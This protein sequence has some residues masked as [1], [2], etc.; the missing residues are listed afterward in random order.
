MLANSTIFQLIS[1]LLVALYY[2]CRGNRSGYFSRA[3]LSTTHHGIFPFPIRGPFCL[4]PN[5]FSVSM[6]MATS[7]TYSRHSIRRRKIHLLRHNVLFGRHDV[8]RSLRYET[9]RAGRV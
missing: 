3:S 1:P 5:L 9:Q 8:S 4:H 2:H 6:P 7:T